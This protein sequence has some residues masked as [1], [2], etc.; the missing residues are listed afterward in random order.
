MDGEVSFV[1]KPVCFAPL[2]S[3]D[4]RVNNLN[5]FDQKTVNSSKC[6]RANGNLQ[7]PNN[8]VKAVCVC[9]WRL[10]SLRLS[11]A[12]INS[13][14]I[15]HIDSVQCC[16]CR[17]ELMSSSFTPFSSNRDDS[18]WFFIIS[19][20]SRSDPPFLYSCPNRP[21]QL[22]AF[23]LPCFFFVSHQILSVCCWAFPPLCS[24]NSSSSSQVLA[25][26]LEKTERGH[27]SLQTSTL[28]V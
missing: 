3:I 13:E 28:Q 6:Y 27:N 4:S 10:C 8:T 16:L 5:G 23:L 20:L 19:L 9:L 1:F 18:D 7:C 15:A 22:V 2:F 24:N 14:H 11:H 17:W 21:I 25:D 12:G 26:C